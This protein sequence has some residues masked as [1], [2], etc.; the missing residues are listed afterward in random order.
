MSIE[1]EKA[2]KVMLNIL[3]D[4]DRICIKHDLTYW[5]DFGTLLGAVRHEG[6]IPW[7][8][9]LDVSM[10]RDDYN[11]F[12]KI[13]K[14]ELDS[15]YFLQNKNTDKNIF[16]HFSKIR[17]K[18]SLYVEKHEVNQNIKYHQGIYIDIFPVNYIKPS[19]TSRISY[20]FIKKCI[21]LFSNRY[22]SIDKLS[23]P[24][25]VF[26]NLYH[27]SKNTYVVRGPEMMTNELKIHKEYLF[28]LTKQQFEGHKFNAP[29]DLDKYL[30]LFYGDDYMT[31]PPKSKR[32]THAYSIE[33][34][35]AT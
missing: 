32:K 26:L 14:K 31:L 9:D 34:F 4:F 18:N 1:L 27:N 17:D 8:D 3:L 25:I 15:K 2:K 10:P 33:I 12:L 7:D 11:K 16:I 22:I 20:D 13:A 21:K 23:N 30:R 29:K 35:D 6:F 5:L 28:P 24:L 19:I